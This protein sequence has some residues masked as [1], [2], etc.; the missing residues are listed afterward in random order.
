MSYTLLC[1]VMFF[2]EKVEVPRSLRPSGSLESIS[3]S[4]AVSY[5]KFFQK[6]GEVFF[7]SRGFTRIMTQD[8]GIKLFLVDLFRDQPFI[9]GALDK[10]I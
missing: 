3:V 5:S 7:Q 6:R 2:K 9:K 4:R 8:V 1:S 10:A